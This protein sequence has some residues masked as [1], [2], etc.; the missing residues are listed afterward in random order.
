MQTGQ[1]F[2]PAYYF[3]FH[4]K[5]T[6]RHDFVMQLMYQELDIFFIFILKLFKNQ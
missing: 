1:E 5:K 6:Q 3:H 4:S 2:F